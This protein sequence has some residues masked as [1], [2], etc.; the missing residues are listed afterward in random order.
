MDGF[1]VYVGA[2]DGT[3]PGD[4]SNHEKILKE[5]QMFELDQYYDKI[6]HL[7]FETKFVDISGEVI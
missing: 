1:Q 4:R 7:T 5:R 2:D 3:L 6:S